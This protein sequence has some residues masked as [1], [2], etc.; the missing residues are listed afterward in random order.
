MKEEELVHKA[1]AQPSRTPTPVLDASY[2]PAK[3]WDGLEEVG[4]LPAPEFYFEGFMPPEKVTD[5]YEATAALHRAVVEVFT[6]RQAGR[7]LSDLSNA[8]RGVDKTSEVNISVS[9]SNPSAP[10]LKFSNSVSEEA[11]LESLNPQEQAVAT[12]EST[13]D[14]F[15]PENSDQ[16]SIKGSTTTNGPLMEDQSP[17]A[18][19]ALQLTKHEHQAASWNPSW[20]NISLVD[21]EI[22]FAVSEASKFSISY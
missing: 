16:P 5:P 22:K 17:E 6:L 12:E 20:V 13:E 9:R 10:V 15:G 8:G 7:P 1:E 4:E 3:T 2:E 21:T 18:I 19:E 14:P 11:I